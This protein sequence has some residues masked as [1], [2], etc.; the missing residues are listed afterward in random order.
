MK[1]KVWDWLEYFIRLVIGFLFIYAA[2]GKIIHPEKFAVVVYNYRVLPI[3]LV[4]IVA[5]LVPWLEIAIGVTLILGVWL[6]TAAFLLCIL[7]IGF[8]VLIISAIVRGL[9]IECG[10][11]TL[12]KE[13]A[14]VSWKRVAEDVLILA[15]GL[16]IFF[17]HLPQ[18]QSTTE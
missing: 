17:R 11:F 3:E 15:G 6:E 16:F 8:I 4:N 2:I 14:L 10:C 5:I 9:N 7:T 12:T 1:S 13:G 18:E